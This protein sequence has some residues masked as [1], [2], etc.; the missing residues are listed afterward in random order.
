MPPSQVPLG[1]AALAALALAALASTAAEAPGERLT[2][3]EA[4]QDE[5]LSW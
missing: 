4:S 1:S 5:K 2:Q 3:T